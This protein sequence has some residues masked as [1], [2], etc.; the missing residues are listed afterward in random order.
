VILL[1]GATGYIGS[2]VWLALH[3][4]GMRVLGLDNFCNSSRLVLQRLAA[5]GADTA[6]F[7]E[8][9][10]TDR[11]ALDEVFS[12]WTI[13]AVVHF[14]AFKAVPESVSNPLSYYANNVGGLITL[15]AVMQSHDC[16]TLVFSSSASVYGQPREL[17]ITEDA[18]LI[19]SSPYGATKLMC[20]QI[21]RDCQSADPAW[22]IGTLRYFNPVGAHP[23]GMIGED[24]HGIPNNVMPYIAQVAVGRR[25]SLNVFGT[26]YDTRDGT[27]VRDY[28]HVEDL[29]EGHVAALEQLRAATTSFTLNLG[30]G[31]GISVLELLRAFELA[32]GRPIPYVIGPRRPGDVA[33]C[34]ADPSRA[35]KMLNWKTTRDLRM[36]CE[37][38]WRWQSANP[39][40]YSS[41]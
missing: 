13:E 31:R 12:R 22:R 16:K 17:P 35:E 1:T 34:Y 40:G 5:L 37:D 24:P 23:S 4:A 2:H 7:V 14:A 8:A 19:P 38:S 6:T 28:I 26:D 39:D 33:S 10:V 9:D 25:P 11:A 27:G 36:M 41:N 15:A 32:S 29:A 18:P 20:E 30:T 21:L 3:R